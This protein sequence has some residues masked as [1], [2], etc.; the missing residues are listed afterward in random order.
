MTILL[1]IASG[2]DLRPKPWVNLD[3]VPKWPSAPRGCDVIWDGRKDP[4][5]FEDASVQEVYCG[6]TLLHLPPARHEP[7][8]REVHRVLE[9]GGVA[10]FGEVDMAL[11]MPRW[12]N[13]PDDVGLSSLIW[14]EHGEL[15][16][17]VE[18]AEYDAHKWG[19]TEAKLR[20]VLTDAGFTDIER[21]RIHHADVFYELTL[22]CRSCPA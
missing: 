15:A 22:R 16:H 1:N 12:L 13:S 4:L 14:G 20:R 11:V 21:I 8:L 2:T 5:P 18:F 6:Y 9:P 19:F 7:L 17:G 10:V 3:V